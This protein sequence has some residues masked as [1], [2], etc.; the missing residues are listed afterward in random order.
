MFRLLGSLAVTNLKKNRGLYFPYGL[1]VVTMLM[2]TYILHALSA[3]PSLTQVFGG[4]GTGVTLSLGVFVMQVVALLTILY[5]NSFVM[6]NRSKELGLYSILGLDRVQI[7]WLSFIET[8]IFA[9]GTMLVG[10]LFGMVFHRL[11]FALLLKAMRYPIALTYEMGVGSI[12]WTILFFTIIFVIVAIVNAFR[13]QSS[14]PLELLKAKKQGETKGRFM[15]LRALVGFAL[16]AV[17][18]YQ[19]Q[20]IESPIKSLY[21]FF[22]DVIFVI[23]ATYILFDAGSIVFLRWLKHQKNFYY[24]PTNFI[25]I[26]NLIF[27]MRKNAAGLAS[28]CILSTMVLVTLATTAAIQIGADRYIDQQFSTEYTFLTSLNEAEDLAKVRKEVA[29]IPS[30]SSFQASNF[31]DMSY[32]LTAGVLEGEVLNTARSGKQVLPEAVLKII[33]L[34]DYNQ[35]LNT[36]VTLPTGQVMVGDTSSVKKQRAFNKIQLANTMFSVKEEFDVQELNKKVPASPMITDRNYFVIMNDQ[37]IS[38]LVGLSAGEEQSPFVRMYNAFWS[39]TAHTVEEKQSE[40]EAYKNYVRNHS[41][42]EGEIS[43]KEEAAQLLFSMYGSLL[44]L[45]I[46]LSIAFLVGAILVIYYKQVSEGYED[47]E[48]YVVLKK[49]GIDQP[50]I[51]RSINRQVLIVFFLPLL[52]A[53]LH[54]AM[55]LKMVSLIVFI[56]GIDPT[57]VQLTMIAVAG[58]FLVVYTIIYRLTSRSYFKIINR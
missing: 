11:A 33:P 18:Y 58:I 32:I 19:S 17:A 15:V 48:R 43:A 4:G 24:K 46:L 57:I 52:T 38:Q 36:S 21:M 25:S 41:T 1:T 44:F 7:Q 9:V 12:L 55:S 50:T 29:E 40:E 39:S 47:R 13:V 30:A 22:I 45:G 10:I 34:S 26:S 37:E 5:A 20:T 42:L 53:F 51:H 14:R 54:T 6:K 49:I 56:F 16:L 31:Y 35:L 23:L 2:L 3:S 28:I 8:F 27:R